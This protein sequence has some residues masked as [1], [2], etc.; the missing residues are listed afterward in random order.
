[1]TRFKIP[2]RKDTHPDTHPVLDAAEKALGFIPNLH[3]LM[4][5]NPKV[6]AGWVAL[7]SNLAQ[8]LDLRTRD[9]I[10]LAVTEVNGCTYCRAAHTYGATNFAKSTTEEIALNKQGKSGDPKRGAAALFAKTVTEKR[11]DI[12]DA[13]LAAVRAAGWTDAEIVAIVALGAQFLMTNFLN[14]VAQTT[15]DF[16][17][18][19]SDAK[20]T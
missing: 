15:A 19:G 1:M 13:D 11:G 17:S 4:A 2:D 12:D 10:A 18:L 16:P 9:A 6:L 14:N 5:L 7:Q 20:V 8:T 3:R